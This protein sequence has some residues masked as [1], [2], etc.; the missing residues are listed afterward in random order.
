MKNWKDYIEEWRKNPDKAVA[1]ILTLLMNANIK[2]SDGE[3]ISFWDGMILIRNS[4]SLNKYE[5]KV[6][7]KPE[8]SG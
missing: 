6:E 2:G 7:V 5:V 3:F 4:H 8:R 1:Y